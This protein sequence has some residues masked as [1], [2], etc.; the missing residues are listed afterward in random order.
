M[1]LGKSE[2]VCAL[3]HKPENFMAGSIA[4]G[5]S[6]WSDLTLDKWILDVVKCYKLGFDSKPKQNYIPHPIKLPHND[7]L[8]LEEA[9]EELL[10]S[11]VI[12]L[13]TDLIGFL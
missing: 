2:K 8:A 9:L 1:S 10:D 13:C 4:K 12:K 6:A 5:R 3:R 11:G 7:Q